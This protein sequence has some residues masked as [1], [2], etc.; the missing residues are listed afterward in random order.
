MNTDDADV[1]HFME[2]ATHLGY[3]GYEV[4]PPLDGRPWFK[5]THPDHWTFTFTRWNA[6]LWLRCVVVLPDDELC[7]FTRTLEWVNELRRKASIA[8]YQAALE[9]DGERVVEAS[10]L[11]PVAYDRHSF[12]S[13]ML[14]WVED[15]ARLASA[16]V[17][18][19]RQ[20]R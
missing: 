16:R 17:E 4:T 10:A 13:Y 14:K 20:Q 6:F 11:L 7:D 3:F 9:D 1:I 15:T 12:G 19:R 8:K 18:P 5:A 2:F